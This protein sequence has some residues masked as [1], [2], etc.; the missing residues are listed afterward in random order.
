MKLTELEKRQLL[1]TAVSELSKSWPDMELLYVG[2][3]KPLRDRAERLIELIDAIELDQYR[4]GNN[5][6][7]DTSDD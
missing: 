2:S 6:R 7:R 4:A 3:L 1:R 5:P